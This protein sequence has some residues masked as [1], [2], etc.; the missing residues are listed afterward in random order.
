MYFQLLVLQYVYLQTKRSGTKFKMNPWN[1]PNWENPS[2]SNYRMQN[3][4]RNQLLAAISGCTT[5]SSGTAAPA[6]PASAQEQ[7]TRRRTAAAE[8]DDSGG[9][10]ST[11]TS[12]TILNPHR[13]PPRAGTGETNPRTVI[14]PSSPRHRR[15]FV[16]GGSSSQGTISTSTT[17]AP[18]LAPT[19]TIN[20]K[21]PGPPR[22]AAHDSYDQHQHQQ[23]NNLYRQKRTMKEVLDDQHPSKF[24]DV[25]AAA[26]STSNTRNGIAGDTVTAAAAMVAQSGIGTNS[27]INRTTFGATAAGCTTT[28]GMLFGAAAGSARSRNTH[29]IS[30][31]SSSSSAPAPLSTRARMIVAGGAAPYE[32]GRRLLVANA[33]GPDSSAAAE[34]RECA[35]MLTSTGGGANSSTSSFM[36][37]SSSRMIRGGNTFVPVPSNVRMMGI[38]SSSFGSNNNYAN[39]S[40]IMRRNNAL[41]N[42]GR[43]NADTMVGGGGLSFTDR[44]NIASAAQLANQDHDMQGRMS[45][46]LA[47]NSL[48][49]HPHAAMFLANS[50]TAGTAGVRYYSIDGTELRDNFSSFRSGVQNDIHLNREFLPRASNIGGA[51]LFPGNPFINRSFHDGQ[52]AGSVNDASFI[53]GSRVAS[54]PEE[55]DFRWTAQFYAL[56][57]FKE[58]FGHCNVPM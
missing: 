41:L 51:S 27:T 29:F 36:P 25:S 39:A 16:L 15:I 26:C 7:T 13:P 49:Q 6:A 56:R 37:S 20:E 19:T 18:A 31:P 21:N 17:A 30:Y 46:M 22:S 2:N 47:P 45:G 1:F 34:L 50:N 43:N 42:S 48:Q 11:S 58:E 35:G 5:S 8:D 44:V 24:D 3:S 14:L 53:Y 4:Y 40:L 55:E 57:R 28:S 10:T 52:G 54:T 33:H 23:E 32:D 12:S 38:R 9:P